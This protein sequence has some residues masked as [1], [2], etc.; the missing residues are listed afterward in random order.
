MKICMH[1]VLLE[2]DPLLYILLN[3]CRNTS[4]A[5]RNLQFR[6]ALMQG[7][8]GLCVT[9]FRKTVFRTQKTFLPNTNHVNCME[10][11]C[12]FPFMRK[13]HLRTGIRKVKS[14]VIVD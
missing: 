5:A 2:A 13:F 14:Y 7:P 8:G 1:I 10:C 4:I 3:L 12:R 11:T 9:N 6:R